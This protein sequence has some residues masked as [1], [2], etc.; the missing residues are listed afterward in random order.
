MCW[1]E[2]ETSETEL[3]DGCVCVCIKNA[4]LKGRMV[5]SKNWLNK[6]IFMECLVIWSIAKWKWESK[7]AKK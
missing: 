1:K 6:G 4:D 5:E 7:I 2:W 3:S